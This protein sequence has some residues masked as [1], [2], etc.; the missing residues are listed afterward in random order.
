MGIQIEP[1]DL[2]RR[3]GDEHHHVEQEHRRLPARSATRRR[4]A[5]K[6]HDLHDHFEHLLGQ[7]VTEPGLRER[8]REFLRGGGTA[9]D[10]PRLRPPPLFK[11]RT[12][13]GAVVELRPA[14]AGYALFIDGARVDHDETPWHLEPDMR[15]RVQ[16]GD[17][18]CD[19]SFDASQAAVRSLGEFLSGRASPPW[20]WA[21]ELIEDGLI[22]T[23]L[24]LT[25]RGRRCLDRARPVEAPPARERN[26][27]VLVADGV[28]ARVFVLDAARDGGGPVIT[29]LVELAEIKNPRLR[30]R[31]VELLS[32][33]RPGLRR[34]GPQGPRHAVS[35]HREDRRRE[36][37]R[38]FAARVAAEA[39][40]V[41]RRY[42]ACELIV[43]ASP[44][45]LGF[46]RPAIERQI[47]AKDQIA[48]RDLPRDLT[49]LST[50]MLHDLLAE[51]E[52]LPARGRR[53]PLIPAP[54]QPA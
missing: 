2:L 27:C 15:G 23:E 7:W 26:V 40:G 8:W 54:G 45:M 34:E 24:A 36:V 38:Q 12:D 25:P 9:P 46:L 51:A 29:E 14:S 1:I 44:R 6:L 19:E 30:A 43:A 17:H 3:L 49:T 21:R 22:D 13:A 32:E 31:D 47:R 18:A 28:R 53:A 39:A 20:Q 37:E 5:G 48:M 35:D 4:L 10:A 16:I 52:L 33:S 50:P 42:P 11:G 41:W